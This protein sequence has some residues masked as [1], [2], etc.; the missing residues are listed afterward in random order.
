[1]NKKKIKIPDALK[2][3][4]A[5]IRMNMIMSLAS[6]FV[7]L[8]CLIMMGST[9]LIIVNS[10]LFIGK[11]EQMNEISLFIE[12]TWDE[13]QIIILGEQIKSV[14]NV[15]SSTFISREQAFE[16]FKEENKSDRDLYSGLEKN[17]LR[18]SYLVKVEDIAYFDKTVESLSKLDGV[19]KVRERKDVVDIIYNIRQ[20]FTTMG[21]WIG[22]ILLSISI[23]IISNTIKIA[24]FTRKKEINIMKFVGATDSFIRMPFILEGLFLGVVGGVIAFFIQYLI[25]KLVI[26]PFISTLGLIVPVAFSSIWLLVLLAF[27]LFGVLIGVLSSVVTMRKYLRV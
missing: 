13:E 4:F 1:M 5:N 23:F 8:S 17:P 25:Y 27:L 19:A 7:L 22:V 16:D 15:L 2:D 21:I 20:V 6:V 12:E 3:A 14:P 26:C 18:D 9:F 11:M 24:M 10:S